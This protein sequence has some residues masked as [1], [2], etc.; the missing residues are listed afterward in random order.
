MY[1]PV[2]T[3]FVS[4]N[5]PS[6]D[7]VSPPLDI[8]TQA[9]H[10]VFLAKAGI[11]G[12]V[13]LGS[14]GESVHLHP[15]ERHVLFAGVRAGLDKAGFPS[16]PLIAGTATTNIAE[17]VEQLVEARDAGMQYGM[18]LAPGY[19]AGVTSQEGL[20]DWF[21][22]VADRSPIPILVYVLHS[23]GGSSIADILATTSP[24]CPTWSSS[25]HRRL[26]LSRATPI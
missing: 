16:F 25:P 9:A 7:A 8:E 15:R 14:T 22:A 12:L 17:T 10:A 3:F 2:P 13:I 4:K 6:Y 1:V 19:N 5:S 21:T 26:L 23:H 18:V 24:A 20:V 11:R